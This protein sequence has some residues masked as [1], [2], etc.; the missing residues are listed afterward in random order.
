MWGPAARCRMAQVWRHR[1]LALALVI[2]A[3]YA[4]VERERRSSGELS[5]AR[6]RRDIERLEEAVGDANLAKERCRSDLANAQHKVSYQKTVESNMEQRAHELVRMVR[7]LERDLDDLRAQDVAPEDVECTDSRPNGASA[8]DGSPQAHKI[9]GSQAESAQQL[10]MVALNGTALRLSGRGLRR[11]AQARAAAIRGRDVGPS[12]ASASAPSTPRRSLPQRWVYEN[13]GR[14]HYSHMAMISPLPTHSL[15]KWIVVW[16]TAEAFEGADD[17]HLRCAFSNDASMWTRPIVL[18]LRQTGCLWSP[19][20]ALSPRGDVL[21]LFYAESESCIR[22]ANEFEPRRWNVGGSIK[23]VRSLDG[24]A[25]TQPTT[26]YSQ[27]AAGGIPKVIANPPIITA[28][29]DWL[30]PWWQE[31]PRRAEEN[32]AW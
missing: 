20:L 3:C 5:L 4:L 31:L 9:T 15:F 28:N 27:K 19:V 1:V 18:P 25:W 26:I 2:L 17:Q 12:I 21:H 11:H 6:A 24:V 10:L 13:E 7:E 14:T 16:Q 29:G 8:V 30:L 32:D 22:P 23:V